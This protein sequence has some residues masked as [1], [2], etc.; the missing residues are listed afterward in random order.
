M[1]KKLPK[2][3]KKVSERWK[4]S[5]EMWVRG[6]KE[7]ENFQ[8]VTH[9]NAFNF[10]FARRNGLYSL[11]AIYR[12]QSESLKGN[13]KKLCVTATLGQVF[14]S[15]RMRDGSP[16]FFYLNPYVGNYGI[17]FKEKP[18]KVFLLPYIAV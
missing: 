15:K 6:E 7:K 12:R 17:L 5:V 2:K 1:Q 13:R 11:K 9:F 8:K 3:G 4:L 10:R 14:P 18:S 16:D